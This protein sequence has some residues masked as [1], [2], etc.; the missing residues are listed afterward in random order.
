M[1]QEENVW[2][3]KFIIMRKLAVLCDI[4]SNMNNPT[5]EENAN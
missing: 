1:E 3:L 5:I 2:C 4:V